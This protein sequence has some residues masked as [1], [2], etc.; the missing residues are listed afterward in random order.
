MPKRPAAVDRKLGM[1]PYAATRLNTGWTIGLG[2]IAF[3][4]VMMGLL[5]Y[6]EHGPRELSPAAAAAVSRSPHETTM[7]LF[8][9]ER[10]VGQLH[11]EERPEQRDG[12]AGTLTRL[13]VHAAVDLFGRLTDFDLAGEAWRPASTPRAVFKFDVRSADYEFQVDGRLADGRLDAAVT[14]AGETTPLSFPVSEELVF[15]GGFGTAVEF[16]S[17]AVGEEARLA[18]F[19]PLTLQKSTLRVRCV[20]EETLT[21]AGAPTSARRLD[22]TS[23]AM[24]SQVWI[25]GEGGVLQIVAPL[26]WTLRREVREIR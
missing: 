1:S 7:G 16:P 26:G 3:W 8:M 13:E 2:S 17:L 24:R 22:V 12:L 11:V 21:V 15:A 10:R 9:G 19:D 23:G 5:L 20:A 6:R 4:L 14:S 25:D 18:S